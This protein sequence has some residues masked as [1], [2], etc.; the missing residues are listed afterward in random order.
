MRRK[1]SREFVGSGA[2]PLPFGLRV[3]AFTMSSHA[4][5]P[6]AKSLLTSSR[7]AE[8]RLMFLSGALERP[9]P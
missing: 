1:R 7:V 3:P 5:V 2:L 6:R 8:A 4:R 9:V